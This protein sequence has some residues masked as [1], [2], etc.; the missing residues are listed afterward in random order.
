MILDLLLD[1]NNSLLYES[2]ALEEVETFLLRARKTLTAKDLKKLQE[3]IRTAPNPEETE[4]GKGI[5][6]DRKNRFFELIENKTEP[7]KQK[8]IQVGRV[9]PK[10][11]AK[12]F[13]GLTND[14]IAD[15]L[16][17]SQHDNFQSDPFK[18]IY[19]DWE[20]FVPFHPDRSWSIL[21][22]DELFSDDNLWTKTAWA[23]VY[24]L[25]EPIEK[26]VYERQW[27]IFSI[28]EGFLENYLQKQ[29]MQDPMIDWLNRIA[30]QLELSDE[31]YLG[32]WFRFWDNSK[33]SSIFTST[34]RSGKD[35]YQQD[36][37]STSIN[38]A[39]GKLAEGIL[40]ALYRHKP[41][42][43]FRIPTPLLRAFSTIFEADTEQGWLAQL[44]FARHFRNLLIINSEWTKSVLLP[45]FNYNKNLQRAGRMWVGFL[46]NPNLNLESF[47]IIKPLLLGAIQIW[48]QMFP[49]NMFHLDELRRN[50]VHLIVFYK[51]SFPKAITNKEFEN[52][53]KVL[54]IEDLEELFSLF[55]DLLNDPIK[56]GQEL[57]FWE[58]SLI[59][60]L[61]KFW[62]AQKQ[63]PRI[64]LH[65]LE[66]TAQCPN[67]IVAISE[68][69]KAKPFLTRADFTH[70]R[71]IYSISQKEDSGFNG[72]LQ[73][74]DNAKAFFSLFWKA[75]QDLTEEETH[76]WGFYYIEKFFDVFIAKYPTLS[77]DDN[78]QK[79]KK[80]FR[81]L[82]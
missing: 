39:R 64:S 28:K 5:T 73:S 34:I 6:D 61:N 41:E 80:K 1:A 30:S 74:P 16:I 81:L 35:T 56:N 57:S 53:F 76:H 78:F 32:Y 63:S 33:N 44:T 12:E 18:D 22:K 40:D 47:E 11:T 60:F 45:A 77:K 13:F 14:E 55:E 75:V 17:Q 43:N 66:L 24:P 20:Q 72:V 49:P 54:D 51:I 67:A 69:L 9:G 26:E 79:A 19:Q 15:A 37:L 27:E 46:Y 52:F 3:F 48:D 7:F 82:F 38:D 50:L 70:N 31:I 59:P 58:M 23:L 25:N 29:L 36:Y 10:M 42:L 21:Q 4:E 2:T 71:F 62:P 65:F 68:Y 8:P